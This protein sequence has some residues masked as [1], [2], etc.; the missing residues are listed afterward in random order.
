MGA[1]GCQAMQPVVHVP[2]PS[3]RDEFDRFN[4]ANT[5]KCVQFLNEVR[6]ADLGAPPELQR[7]APGYTVEVVT[8]SGKKTSVEV[9]DV[10][11][12][13]QLVFNTL[14]KQRKKKFKPL[15]DVRREA[16]LC[17]ANVDLL[18]KASLKF[19]EKLDPEF[20]SAQLVVPMHSRQVIINYTNVCFVE[21]VFD[22]PL[23]TPPYCST[24]G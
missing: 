22:S 17:L 21:R 8:K 23:H 20:V 24:G 16:C 5:F 11:G 4:Q 18:S 10:G 3:N 14:E 6:L 2:L 9:G 7:L 1:C 13:V 15:V 12:E 19:L